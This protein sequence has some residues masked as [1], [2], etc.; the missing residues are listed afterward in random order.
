M[1]AHGRE[2]EFE[3]EALI[4][5]DAL[6]RYAVRLTQ[7][8]S[9]AEDLVQETYLKAYRCF[10]Q[11][12]R[13][14]NCR[15]WLQRILRNSFL[16]RIKKLGR[17]ILEIDDARAHRE[18]ETK[19]FLSVIHHPEEEFFQ[20]VMDQE[21]ERALESLPILFREAVVLVDLEDCSYK[22]AAEICGIPIGTVMS[23][24]ARGRMLLK[25]AL[26]SY[27]RERGVLRGER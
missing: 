14:T 2:R 4:H 20:R 3:D 24:L 19:E 11:F 13:G 22:E 8:R 1:T 15:A 23:R 9:E 6:Y 17:E 25:Q 21:V 12:D 7:N 16:N 10:H 26:V 5:M 27:A 18:E